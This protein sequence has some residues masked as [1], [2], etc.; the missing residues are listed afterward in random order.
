MAVITPITKEELKSWGIK[1]ILIDAPIFA[2]NVQ[3]TCK[4]VRYLFNNKD[5]AKKFIEEKQKLIPIIVYDVEK[6]HKEKAIRDSKFVKE[7]SFYIQL[8]DINN[9]EFTKIYENIKNTTDTIFTFNWD[10]SNSNL[11]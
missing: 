11:K 6:V 9:I 2:I 1:F 10:F 5:E 4:T 8:A 3:K 7:P